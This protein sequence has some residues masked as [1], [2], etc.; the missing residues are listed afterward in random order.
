[1]LARRHNN[2]EQQFESPPSLNTVSL[3]RISFF[4]EIRSLWSVT[5]FFTKTPHFPL[6]QI[7]CPCGKAP[8]GL[9]HKIK[10]LQLK[11]TPHITTPHVSL[12]DMTRLYILFKFQKHAQFTFKNT[13]HIITPHVLSKDMKR[14][15]ILFEFRKTCAIHPQEEYRSSS[16]FQLGKGILVL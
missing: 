15:Y 12:T 5:P 7:N 1:M 9:L 3:W 8:L 16:Q 14:L 6:N 13:P 4:S 10:S 11:H 2:D